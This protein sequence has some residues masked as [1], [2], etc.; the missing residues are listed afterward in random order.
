MI[1]SKISN[2][3][4]DLEKLDA[5]KNILIK[6]ARQ[7]NLKNIDVVIPRNTFTVITGVSGSGKS[8]LAFDTL[9]AEGQRRYVESLSSYARQFLARLDKPEV[10]YIKGISPAIAI[11][12]KVISKNSRSSVGT[13]TEIYDYLKVLYAR[14]GKI[15]SPVTG[16]EVIAESTDE[17]V[18]KLLYYKGEKAIVYVPSRFLKDKEVDE[19]IAEGYSRARVGADFC[20]LES[21]KKQD[22][23]TFDLVLDR[24]KVT[25]DE[26]FISAVKDS[27]E[28]VYLLTDGYCAIDV[29]KGKEVVT[30]NFSDHIEE[31]GVMFEEPHVNLFNHNSPTGACPTCEGYGQTL[32]V[33]ESLVVPDVSKS[34]YGGAVACWNT[35]N[36]LKWKD[37]FIKTAAEIEFP[38]HRAYYELDKDQKELLWKGG[39]GVQGIDAFFSQKQKEIYKIQNRVLISRYKGRALCPECNGAKLRKEALYV[40]I[41][42]KTIADITSLNIQK[43]HD[44]ISTLNFKGDELKIADRLVHE[45]T[46]RLEFLINVGVPYITLDRSASTLSGGESQRINLASSLGSSLV[47]ALYVLDEPSIGLHPK[48][49]RKL[50]KVLKQLNQLGNTVVVVEHDEDIIRSASYLIDIGPLAGSL[51]GELVFQGK[52]SEMLSSNSLTAKYLSG[53]LKVGKDGKGVTSKKSIKLKHAYLHNLQIEEITFPLNTLTVVMG[54]SGSGKS[55]LLLEELVPQVRSYLNSGTTSKLS[56]DLDLIKHLEY[57]NQNPIGRS[58]RSNPVTY[59]KA[60]DDIRAMF[61]AQPMSMLRGYKPGFFSLNVPGGRCEHCQGEGQVTVEMQFMADLKIKCTECEGKKFKDEILEVHYQGLSIGEVLDLTVEDAIA[62]FESASSDKKISFESKIIA[63][64]N[65]LKA[66]G[67]SYIKL[68]QASSTLSGGEAQRVKLAFFLI[69]GNVQKHTLFIFDEPT[70]GLH[71]HDVNQLL[72]SFTQ[73]IEQGHT[74]FVIEHNMD[75][76]KCS[77]HLIELGPEGGDGGG[78][79]TFQGSARDFFKS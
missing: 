28:D 75:V 67:L 31:D 36:Q 64:M 71:F 49:T 20:T 15:I 10:D 35:P 48:D 40:K 30:L 46:S 39:Y 14:L 11:E 66:V 42:D 13:I 68:G 58:S 62:L 47:G 9:Y 32:G 24:I 1:L 3:K 6:G 33:S 5:K 54:M 7:H 23:G 45:I 77:D 43:T 73:L 27:I 34:V 22:K 56:G 37:N 76:A 70:T 55:T 12:Q 41:Q 61:A 50:I 18:K 51:G 38:I 8:T 4:I 19:L 21:L 63:K 16:K 74:V 26:D 17:I 57:V 72:Y 2:V 60:Y 44:W 65:P 78:Q 59:I 29:W 25:T 53:A 52:V 79:I 69:K